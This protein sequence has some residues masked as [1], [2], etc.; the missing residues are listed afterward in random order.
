MASLIDESGL[1]GVE[2]IELWNQEDA[3]ELDQQLGVDTHNFAISARDWTIETIVQQIKQGNIDL[4]PAFQRRNAW[5][6]TRRSRLFEFFILGFPVPQ[7]VLAENPRK[8]KSYIVIDSKQR[9][10]AV[11]GFFL[12]EYRVFWKQDK[13]SGLDLL[14][15]LN[16]VRLDEFVHGE[17][18]A[19][20]MRQ[21]ANADIRTTV[22]SGFQN[23]GVLYDIFYRINTGSVP[24]SSQELR[25]V[26]NRGDF[27]KFI[28]ETTSRDNELTCPP[29]IRPA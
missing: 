4:D 5:T 23:E 15:E 28:L 3:S 9:L 8:K 13:F 21:L 6:D 26:L 10:M 12:P 24:L 2:E 14:R 29:E 11:A 20:F 7:I 17:S 22:I 18:Y 16:G 27:A 25:Q 1:L 19:G